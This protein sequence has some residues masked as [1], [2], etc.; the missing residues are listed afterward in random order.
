MTNLTYKIE[1]K[2]IHSP[3]FFQF[4]TDYYR[5]VIEKE[6]TLAKITAEDHILCIGGGICPFSAILFHQLTDAKVTVV[7]NNADCIPQAQ[8]IIEQLGLDE[9]IHVRLQEG[10]SNPCLPYSVIHFALQVTPLAQTFAQVERQATNGTRILLRRPKKQVGSFYSR[11][12]R[13]ILS[14]CSYVEH[15]LP[16][17]IGSTLLYQKMS[18]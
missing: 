18:A 16:R 2:A 3:A 11:L 1:R 5:D 4:A 13:S 12:P 6:A 14:R 9:H 15:K 17:N 7:D 8:Q 10:G